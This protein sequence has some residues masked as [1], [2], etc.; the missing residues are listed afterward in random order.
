MDRTVSSYSLAAG[1]RIFFLVPLHNPSNVKTV[2]REA[3]LSSGLELPYVHLVLF[4]L[5]FG[6][7]KSPFYIFFEIK[8]ILS[9]I[10]FHDRY[11]KFCIPS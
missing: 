2:P 10:F 6:V 9:A 7:V 11:R 4:S 8:I 3:I 5:H 1:E